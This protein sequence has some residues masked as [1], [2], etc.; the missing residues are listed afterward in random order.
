MM[1][2]DVAGAPALLRDARRLI[3]PSPRNHLDTPAFG[4]RRRAGLSV[5]VCVDYDPAGATCRMTS[6][7]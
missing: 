1:I 7:L 3:P 6:Y 5:A 4:L 2:S